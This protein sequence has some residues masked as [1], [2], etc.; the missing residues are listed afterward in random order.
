MRG[1]D[2][3]SLVT[4]KYPSEML[5]APRG[6]ARLLLALSSSVASLAVTAAILP[7]APASA[8]DLASIRAQVTKLQQDAT[9]I[10]ENAQQAQVEMTNLQ[11]KL[12]SLQG[13]TSA[14]QQSLKQVQ[15]TI[16]AIAREQYMNSGLGSG[17]Q[18][19]FSS[20][21]SL[22]LNQAGTLEILTSKKANNV[23]Q[24]TVAKQRLQASSLVV[25]DQLAQIKA[26]HLRY[27]AAQTLASKKLAEAEKL[28]SKLTK[29]E[30]ARLA[31]EQAAQ[32][33]SL[34]SYSLAKV[35][36][37]K[38][39]STRGAQA[40]KFAI[41]QIGARYQFGAAGMVYWDCSGLTMRAFGTAGV[42]LPHSAAYQYSFG[43]YIPRSSL[44]PGD[45]VFF[46]RPIGHVGI[47]L[48]GNLMVDAPHAGARVRVESFSSYFGG[49]PYVGARR[50]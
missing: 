46:G 47:F 2:L 35:A 25:N 18:L 38:I 21:P 31:A 1:L 39:G 20:N 4:H 15:S 48:G 13:Q 26:A 28:L 23:R 5:N 19:M 17:V 29:A 49:E 12:N 10:A 50:I 14:E 30:Q 40:L 11:S 37:L 41:R 42:S 3:S 22:Y 43:K 32:D 7:S 8:T 34:N 45:L 36:N 27:V 9:A 24:L 44:R 33:Q 6:R 16:G